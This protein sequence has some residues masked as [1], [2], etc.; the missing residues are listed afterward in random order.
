MEIN[1]DSITLFPLNKDKNVKFVP[2]FVLDVLYY[3]KLQLV[4]NIIVSMDIDLL[5]MM[6]ELENVKYVPE[7]MLLDVLPIITEMKR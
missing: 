4:K 6:K 1:P 5:L 2:N 7:V 3:L